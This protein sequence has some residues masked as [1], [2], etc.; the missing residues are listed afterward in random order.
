MASQLD[1]DVDQAIAGAIFGVGRFIKKVFRGIKKLKSIKYIIGLLLAVVMSF[2][3]YKFRPLL[4]LQLERVNFPGFLHRAVYILLFFNP[5]IY[6]AIIGSAGEREVEKFYK[7][8]QEIEF[9]GRDGK[10][11]YYLKMYE[12]DAKRTI[13]LFKTSISLGDWKKNQDRLEMALDCTILQMM[14]KAS[15][16]VVELT[17]L[18][19]EYKLTEMVMWDDEF[20]P[21]KESCLAV[22]IGVMGQVTFDLDSTPH[23]LVAGETGS[24][25]SVILH[26]CLW[27]MITKSARVVML[28]FKGGVEFGL[29]YEQ[30]GE[31]V[32]D[33]ERAAEVLEE[34]V[35][36]NALRLA[37]FRNSRVKNITEYNTK[38]NSHLCRIGVFCDEIA[39][40]MDTTGIPKKEREIYEKIKG[41]LSTLARLSRSTG[42]NLI[43]GVQRPDAN[44]LTG[45]IKNNIP[46]R[47]C[48][49]FADKAA[50][51]IVL[52][53]TAATGLPEIKGRFLFLRGNELIE[54]Q[55]YLFK[56]SMLK[57]ISVD[58]GSMLVEQTKGKAK[59]SQYYEKTPTYVQE[60][61]K[62]TKKDYGL[63]RYQDL[64]LDTNYGDIGDNGLIDWSVDK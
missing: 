53:S 60:E 50:S 47:I 33:R 26:V 19:S 48:G 20:I 42:I 12:D 56:D 15:K 64:N 25:K 10:Y 52:N 36:E 30:Y 13:Y 34:L 8:F 59:Q 32:T 21:E 40:M 17:A 1:K 22:G 28:D 54:F 31:V 38:T 11:P 37:L 45:Q 7:I 14:N 39:E 55:A 5:L 46:V 61:E 57:E 16:K 24:G 18:S 44:V 2:L 63:D 9:K 27:Q 4:F 49:R 62:E 6:L 58:K 43:T 29:E 41:L 51:E 3:V 35:R 23:V